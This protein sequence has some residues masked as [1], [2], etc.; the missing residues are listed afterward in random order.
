[1]KEDKQ[2]KAI[3]ANLVKNL[4][5][6]ENKMTNQTLTSRVM[7]ETE[8]KNNSKSGLVAYVPELELSNIDEMIDKA[9]EEKYKMYRANPNLANKEALTMMLKQSAKVPL[10]TL[11]YLVLWPKF[12]EE[13]IWQTDDA[14][15]N[16]NGDYTDSVN[17]TRCSM[18]L[19][20]WV[21]GVASSVGASVYGWHHYFKG[22]MGLVPALALNIGLFGGLASLAYDGLKSWF[23]HDR[24]KAIESYN[25]KSVK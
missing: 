20:L 23:L 12:I 2:L 16:S 15:K 1:M 24:E 3:I 4:G 8:G 25:C 9:R 11:R 6:K 14:W 22:N 19:G 5:V 18:T 17:D 13:Q 10:N 21:G 7:E